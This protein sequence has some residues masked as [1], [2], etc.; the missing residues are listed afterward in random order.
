MSKWAADLLPLLAWKGQ[1]GRK[2][3]NICLNLPGRGPVGL[4]LDAERGSGTVLGAW[5]LA[6]PCG[7]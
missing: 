6:A 2:G 1:A 3:E 4:D 7:S 5:G